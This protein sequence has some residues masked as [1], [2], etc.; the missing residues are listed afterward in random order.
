[1]TDTDSNP[2]YAFNQEFEDE[3]EHDRYCYYCQNYVPMICYVKRD[4]FIEY[5]Q[6]PETLMI[7]ESYEFNGEEYHKVY[8]LIGKVRWYHVQCKRNLVLQNIG[9]LKQISGKNFLESKNFKYNGNH[10][11]TELVTKQK[12]E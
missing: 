9:G 12:R 11:Q 7:G 3:F 5:Y 1:M 10:I 4:N 6:E 8:R 2:E